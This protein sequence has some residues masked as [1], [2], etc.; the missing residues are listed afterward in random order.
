[1]KNRIDLACSKQFDSAN[2]TAAPDASCYVPKKHRSSYITPPSK[3]ANSKQQVVN[4]PLT[5]D[6]RYA[7]TKEET[8]A[9]HG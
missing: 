1:M 3:K 6:T 7:F 4:S 8:A 9:N 2:N 5:D